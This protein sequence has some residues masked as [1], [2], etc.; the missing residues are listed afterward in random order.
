MDDK[1]G[2][3]PL[4]RQP[5]S[6]A[7]EARELAHRLGNPLHVIAG[8]AR[9]LIK[10]MPGNETAKRNL[11]IILSQAERMEGIIREMLDQVDCR[12]ERPGQKREELK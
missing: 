11:D 3:R 12:E 10:K 5:G 6:A 1:N 7:T 2:N 8:R 9:L 4:S